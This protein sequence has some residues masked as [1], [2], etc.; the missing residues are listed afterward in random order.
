MLITGV[1]IYESLIY[2][3]SK[4]YS[5]SF[6]FRRRRNCV[7]RRDFKGK[8]GGYVQNVWPSEVLLVSRESQLVYSRLDGIVEYKVGTAVLTRHSTRRVNLNEYRKNFNQETV[9]AL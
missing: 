9:Q 2:Y 8:S 3:L 4:L 7:R 6:G 1:I 5:L